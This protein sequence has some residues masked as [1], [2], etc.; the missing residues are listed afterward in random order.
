M[1]DSSLHVERLADRLVDVAGLERLDVGAGDDLGVPA[2]E[3][4]GGLGLPAAQP[5]VEL[6]Q[7]DERRVGGHVAGGHQLLAGQHPLDARGRAVGPDD[8]DVLARHLAGRLDAGD[9]AGRGV[10]VDR[11]DSHGVRVAGEQ[12]RRGTLR[13]IRV[14]LGVQLTGEA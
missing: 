6:R 11:D 9:H 7:G 4:F 8:E 12:R 1:R 14:V 2:V 13:Q 10:V 5:V 3:P